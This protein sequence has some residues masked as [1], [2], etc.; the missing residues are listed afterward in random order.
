MTG[1]VLHNEE[2]SEL[3][4][5]PRFIEGTPNPTSAKNEARTR[6]TKKLLVFSIMDVLPKARRE[7]SV[8]AKKTGPLQG[9]KE[10]RFTRKVDPS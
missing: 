5:F 1:I 2:M 6:T 4:R 8:V 9:G 7:P 10:K 3:V